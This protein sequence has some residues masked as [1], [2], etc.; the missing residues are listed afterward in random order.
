[1]Y[2]YT[3]CGLPYVWLTDGYSLEE[4]P[5]GEALSIADVDGLHHTIANWLV[6]H[7]PTLCGREVK[8]LRLEMELTQATLADRLGMTEQTISLWE[9]QPDKQIPPAADRLLRLLTEAWLDNN[10]SLAQAI[11]RIDNASSHEPVARQPFKRGRKDWL[12]AA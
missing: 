11:K 9:R 5:Y 7:L 8:F 4:T 6:E 10:Q 3:E 2:H 1:M 12:V